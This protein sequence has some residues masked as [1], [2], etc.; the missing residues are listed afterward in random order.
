MKLYNTN[1]RVAVEWCNNS[2]ILC[3]NI[4]EVDPNIW[5]N[6][7]GL[8]DWCSDEESEE[9][10]PDVYQ[11]F[12]TDCSQSD[13]K[14]LRDTFGL[15]FAYSDVLDMYVLLVTHYGTSWDYVSWSTTNEYAERKLGREK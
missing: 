13:M 2:Y 14:Y 5:D 11:F 4:T 3:N 8:P 10:M 9:E 7:Q 12:L 6:I 15:W 1:F